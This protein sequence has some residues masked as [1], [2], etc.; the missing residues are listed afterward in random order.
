MKDL[1][2][3]K[4][5]EKN[6]IKSLAHSK[7]RLEYHIAFTQ[8]YRRKEIYGQ[9]K[10]DIGEILR[11]LCEQKDVEIIEAESCLDH[12]HMLMSIPQHIRVSQLL[13]ISRGKVH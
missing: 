5:A 2:K 12:I 1:N 4:K 8:K 7:Y 13:D 6:E 11:K 9:I 10:K 3:M